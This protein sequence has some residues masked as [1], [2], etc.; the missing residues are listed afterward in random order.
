MTDVNQPAPVSDEP[1]VTQDVT[2]KPGE[3][4]DPALLLESLQDEREKRRIAEEKEQAARDEIA[5]LEVEL[6]AKNTPDNDMYSDEGKTLHDQIVTLNE[7]IEVKELREKFPVL[8]DK[9]SEFNEFRK[10]YP[11]VDLEKIA[12]LFLS[13]NGLL[14]EG[15]PRRGLEPAAGGQRTAP[16]TGMSEEDVK[17]LRETNFRKYSQMVREGKIKI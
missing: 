13:E 14:D 11:N 17:N 10:G 3:K 7:K 5:R 15:T 2:P 4:T 6:Q 12:K 1:V 8:K 9:Q 16:N